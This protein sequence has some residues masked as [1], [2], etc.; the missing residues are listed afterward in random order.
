MSRE[1]VHNVDRLLVAGRRLLSAAGES[2]EA[3]NSICGLLHDICGHCQELLQTG[4]ARECLQLVIKAK[5]FRLPVQNLDL[6]R[7]MA[8]L[9]LGQAPSA[10]EALKEE[11]RYF[12]EN[13]SANA[14]LMELTQMASSGPCIVDGSGEFEELHAIVKPYTMVGEQR[15][16]AIYTHAKRVC[17]EGPEG[18]FV[19][20]GVAAGG[21]SALIAAVLKRHGKS[22]A[23]LFSFD[24][25]DGLP[26]P[27]VEDRHGGMH[28]EEAGWGGGTC[29][30]PLESLLSATSSLGAAEFVTPVQGFFEDTLPRMRGVIGPI[31]FL[32]MDG[33]W[34]KSTLDILTNLYDQVVPGGYVQVDDYG[35][36]EGCRKALHEFTSGRCI[37]LALHSIDGIGV[38]FTKR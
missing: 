11:L 25:F 37:D 36:W 4:M 34:Y 31:A 12:P 17:R 38:W 21:S 32:H 27:G 13:A 15:L 8:L 29:A 23:R 3:R 10:V 19:E 5:A 20:C 24:T 30:A 35:Y 2:K 16:R 9:L 1:I 28:A 18:A 33:D 26:S 6:I 7:A 14:L 22:T